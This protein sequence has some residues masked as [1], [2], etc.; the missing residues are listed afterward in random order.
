MA[1]NDAALSSIVT[2]VSNNAAA[3]SSNDA[4][5]VSIS[6]DLAAATRC[7]ST[8]MNY[9]SNC[10]TSSNPCGINQGDCDS[11][12]ECNGDLICGNDNCIDLWP[13]FGNANADCCIDG[14]VHHVSEGT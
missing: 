11:D 3:I 1:N 4:D 9:D 13:S 14:R 12:S 10:C 7:T 5:I 2:D 8:G 6:N